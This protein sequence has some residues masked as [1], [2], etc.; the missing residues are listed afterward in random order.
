MSEKQILND[1][2]LQDENE[3]ESLSSTE[4]ETYFENDD[5]AR[6]EKK[7]INPF[8]K[9]FRTLFFRMTFDQIL[10]G[11]KGNLSIKDMNEI[12]RTLRLEKYERQL[13]KQWSKE[14][15]SK[16]PS[17]FRAIFRQEWMQFVLI[18][19][20]TAIYELFALA[21][22]LMSS[23]IIKWL[24]KEDAGVGM[25]ILWIALT[26]LFQLITTLSSEFTKKWAF[27]LGLRIRNGLIGIIYDKALKLNSAGIVEPGKLI[28]LMGND[29]PVYIGN[30]EMIMFGSASPVMFIVL[31]VLIW[32]NMGKW[33]YVPLVVFVV[34]VALNVFFGMMYGFFYYKFIYAKDKRLSF[35]SEILKNIKFV[36]YN[37]WEKPMVKKT[38]AKRVLEIIFLFFVGF[39]RSLFFSLAIQIGSA[40]S[41]AIF[42]VMIFKEAQFQLAA[43]ITT[44]SLFNSIRV[45]VRTIGL[46]ATCTSTINVAMTRIEKFL[47]TR[48][49]PPISINNSSSENAI[50]MKNVKFIYPNGETAFECEDLNIKKGEF[51]CV[52]GSVGSGKSSFLMSVLSEL[53]RQEGDVTINGKVTYASQ[54]PWLM[55]SSVRENILFLNSFD[56]KKYN[57]VVKDACLVTDI[58]SL[59]GGDAYVVSEKGSN[60]SGGQRQR[61]A[62]ARALYDSKDIMLLDDPLSAVDF[63]VGTYIFENAIQKSLKQKTR[64]I[65]TN[66]MYLLEKADRILV[67]ENNKLA[68]NGSLEELKKSDLASSQLVKT[69]SVKSEKAEDQ[70]EEIITGDAYATKVREESREVGRLPLSVYFNYIKS[71]SFILFAMVVLMLV[72]RIVALYYYNASLTKW[73][74]SLHPLLK[75]PQGKKEFFYQFCYSFIGDTVGVFGCEICLVLFCITVSVRLHKQTINKLLRCKLGFFDIT[76]IGRIQNLFTRDFHM[77]DFNMPYYIEPLIVNIST[78]LITFITIVQTSIYLVIMVLAILIIFVAI[79]SFVIKPVIELQR[80]DSIMRGPIFVHFDQ[81]ILGLPIVRASGAQISFK[82]KLIAKVK[83]NT[84]ALYACKMT[85]YWFL[86]RSDWIGALISIVTVI[87]IVVTKLKH[88]MEPSLAGTALTNITSIPTSITNFAMSLIE[89][90]TFMQSTE[91]ILMINKLRNEESERVKEKYVEPSKLWPTT[92]K[93]EFVDFKFRYR[94]GLPVVLNKISAVVEDKEKLVL[95]VELVVESPL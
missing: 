46:L 70:T 30:I 43:V 48:E 8:F 50:E 39:S 61:I 56:K 10:K 32:N 12:P 80:L 1:I 90:E 69:L 76:P 17:L 87:V 27:T 51:V 41:I 45:P 26:I 79:Y 68:F 53:E 60:L 33:V 15:H 35:F 58:D 16:H 9:F 49:L 31:F 88:S 57:Q 3:K 14:E 92:G 21:F 18:Y 38:L 11:R 78:I 83:N 52:I 66:Q 55:N 84:V 64:I 36:K 42:T 89:I 62:L 82:E 74:K 86:Q 65:V 85:K 6:Y 29:C 4:E 95:L 47:L 5:V 24:N 73:G 44:I 13:S 67:L 94:R 59:M 77:L 72:G 63:Q 71:G 91:R 2:E 54:N 28:N 25:G 34:F 23:F 19:F 40:M 75:L 93:I 81:T 22:P 20:T 37:R 7:K